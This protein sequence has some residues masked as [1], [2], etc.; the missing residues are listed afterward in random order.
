[1]DAV[2]SYKDETAENEHQNTNYISQQI[3]IDAEKK[4][5]ESAKEEAISDETKESAIAG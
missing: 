2:L 5:Q 3:S 4:L 1:M